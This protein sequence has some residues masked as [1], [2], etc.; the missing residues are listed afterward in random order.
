MRLFQTKLEGLAEQIGYFAL[1]AGVATSLA[2]TV[3]WF[4]KEP[5]PEGRNWIDLLR[6]FIVGLTIIVVAVPEGL[7]L[8]VTISLAFSMRRMMKVCP[9][10]QQQHFP[11]ATT[12]VCVA[13][14]RTTI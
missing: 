6:F 5:G 2:L 4:M 10:P 7:P 3:I 8:S 12:M 9:A 13:L 11:R 14:D 1:A